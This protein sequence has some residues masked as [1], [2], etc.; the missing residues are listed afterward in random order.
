MRKIDI[1]I[2][3]LD[4][5]LESKC[6][7]CNK[8]SYE[9]EGVVGCAQG[10]LA[11]YGYRWTEGHEVRFTLGI[12]ALELN[13]DIRPGMAVVSGHTDNDSLIYTVKDPH[14][15]PWTDSEKLGPILT[16]HQILEENVFPE[17]FAFVDSITANDQ[18]LSN[19]IL[20]KIEE[21]DDQ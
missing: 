3:E 17:L 11:Y 21:S 2:D 20:A 9:G 14:S 13:G 12:V 15:S 10:E 6:P 8:P 18:R 7:C 19:R 1:W 4:T 5:E 16:R